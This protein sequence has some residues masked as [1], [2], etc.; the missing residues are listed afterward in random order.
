MSTSPSSIRLDRTPRTTLRRRRERGSHELAA[1]TAILDEGLVGHL[2]VMVDGAPRVIPMAY[3][4]IDRRIFLHGSRSNRALTSLLDGGEVCF[5]VTLIDGLVVARSAFHHSMNYR[6]VVLFGRGDE[7][8]DAADKRA[9]LDAVVG[10]ALRGR[11]AECRGPTDAEVAATTVVALP[12]DEASAKVRTGPPI[13]DAEDMALDVWAGVVPLALVAG[14]PVRDRDIA[15]D[16]DAPSVE[17]RLL[18]RGA[19]PV[20]EERRGELTLTTDPRRVDLDVVHAFLARDA[21]W[22][23]GIARERLV[24]AL[25][26]SLV[27]SVF[28]GAE[29]VAFAR[30]LS[31]GA[32]Y[33]YLMDVFAL[34]SHRRRGIAGW[35][36]AFLRAMPELAGLRRWMLGTR[37]AHALYARH[38]FAPIA[39]P[40]RWMEVV[41]PT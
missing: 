25:S 8:T 16:R 36:V 9:A 23:P 26:R 33:A 27:V 12:I 5:T 3:G 1:I 15:G 4:R 40:E 22:C 38:G 41:S 20:V 2:G 39:Q 24:R 32:T 18:E 31:D 11:P 6:S 29:Q 21:Y 34:P 35:M 10:H 13:D 28:D 37:D 7:V 17:R 19:W 30:L 14:A